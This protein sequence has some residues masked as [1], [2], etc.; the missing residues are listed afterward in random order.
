MRR[1]LIGMA[2]LVMVAAAFVATATPGG[3]G[4]SF[5]NRRFC[6]MGGGGRS[7]IADCG[8]D[9][10]EQCRAAA[11]GNGRYCTENPDWVPQ[12]TEG[13]SRAPRKKSGH[14]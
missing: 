13:R 6:T 7:S 14:S 11:S 5:F 4:E 1:H 12:G 9:T 2:A 8:Y 3:A 10:W